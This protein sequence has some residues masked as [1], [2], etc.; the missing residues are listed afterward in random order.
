MENQLNDVQYIE[1]KI[2]TDKLSVLV[3]N[4]N[5]HEFNHKIQID[6]TSYSKIIIYYQINQLNKLVYL[7]RETELFSK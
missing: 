7:L 4:E 1:F 2:P 6:D 3:E 5:F